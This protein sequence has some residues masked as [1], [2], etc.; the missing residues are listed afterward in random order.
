MKYCIYELITSYNYLKYPLLISC[1]YNSDKF[2]DY[3]KN[4]YNCKELYT[5]KKGLS[6]YLNEPY[7]YM[8][9]YIKND[10]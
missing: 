1:S 5:E 7:Y 3:V 10:Q 6:T 8:L 9:I 4:I 2:I